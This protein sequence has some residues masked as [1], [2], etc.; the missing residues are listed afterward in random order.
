MRSSKYTFLCCI[1]YEITK[2]C[3]RSVVV[4]TSIANNM[5]LLLLL[6][7]AVWLFYKWLISGFDYFE[8]QGVPYVKPY[9]LVGSLLGPMMQKESVVDLTT[10]NYDLFKNSK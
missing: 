8:I 10:R 3:F 4:E 1:S 5:F 9:P 7:L 6:I 2:F